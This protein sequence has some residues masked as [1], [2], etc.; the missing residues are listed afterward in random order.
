MILDI[1][2]QFRPLLLLIIFFFILFFFL[3]LLCLC[4]LL[5][6]LLLL[7]LLLMFLLPLQRPLLPALSVQEFFLNLDD[8]I[9]ALALPPPTRHLLLGQVPQHLPL[10][11]AWHL[12]SG[13]VIYDLCV[14]IPNLIIL[15]F[16]K[17]TIVIFILRSYFT[18][19]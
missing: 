1:L 17:N 8:I 9:L 7:L 18:F 6:I 10:H 12:G 2:V 5:Q 3:L 11:T 15:I 16:I 14:L 19:D 13:G 4:L